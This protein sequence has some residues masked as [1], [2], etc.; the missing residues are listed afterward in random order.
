M[1]TLRNPRHEAFAR[2]L[3]EI[4]KSGGT[5]GRAYT[6]AGYR[7]GNGAAE[8]NASRLL[9]NAN[10]GVADRVKELMAGGA[11][12]AEV[13]VASLLNELEAA[14]A[15]AT[16]VEQYGAAIQ[17]IAGK[18]R[19]AG[20]DRENGDAGG[21]MFSKCETVDQVMAMLVAECGSPAQALAEFDE[22]RGMIETYAASHATLVEAAEPAR[23]A[24][25]SELAQ[26]LALFRP[27][28][29]RR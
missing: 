11:K 24:P 10:N 13:S 17:A 3:V 2:N 25:G 15:G 28:Y 4:T 16:S 23:P 20:L 12:R 5:R 14:R 27:K 6:A 9:S 21:S 1:P 29:R 7:A 19:L 26:S 8:A 18:A 22:L